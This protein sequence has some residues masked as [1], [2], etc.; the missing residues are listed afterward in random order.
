MHSWTGVDN[1][2]DKDELVQEIERL[3]PQF[4]TIMVCL[5]YMDI[6]K[7]KHKPFKEK[8]YTIVCN[9][10]RFDMNFISRHRD[11][12]ELADVTMSN[13]IGTHIGYS[14]ALN[15]PH[16]YFKQNMEQTID[17]SR[18]SE[19]PEQE[20]RIEFEKDFVKT[21]GKF[22]YEITEEQKQFVRYYWGEF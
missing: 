21:F 10:S 15:R 19:I 17:P 11:I 4:E 1:E 9:G 5:Y 8:G 12:I 2:F 18:P 6:Q 20:F 3:K 16:Y 13:G 22:T 14:I 7:G